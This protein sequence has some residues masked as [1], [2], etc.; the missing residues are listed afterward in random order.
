MTLT[1]TK[2]FQKVPEGYI[3]FIEELP[4]ANTQA[5]TLNEAKK[6]GVAESSYEYQFCIYPKV[7]LSLG[8]KNCRENNSYPK[9]ATPKK[10]RRGDSISIRG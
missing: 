6:N 2:I 1:L 7:S 9:S 3:G 4:D 8:F 10:F 5:E